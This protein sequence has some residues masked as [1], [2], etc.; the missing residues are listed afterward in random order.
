MLENEKNQKLIILLST[1]LIFA[2]CTSS[3]VKEYTG[4][5]TY[6]HEVEIF[7]DDKTG[8]EYWIYDGESDKLNRHM[9]ELLIK[10]ETPYSEV[11]VK[12]KG[13]DKGKAT[14]GLAKDEDRVLKVLK[15][16]IIK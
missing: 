7:T 4:M 3:K 10:G 2:G 15:Y 8:Q 12:I 14:N 9:N 5:Y 11:K 6:G 16:D 13:I 1:L